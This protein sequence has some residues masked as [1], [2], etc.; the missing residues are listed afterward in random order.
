MAKPHT[1]TAVKSLNFEHRCSHCQYS[2]K[3]KDFH[4][5]ILNCRKFFPSNKQAE[6]IQAIAD[7]YNL[8]Y[9]TLIRH[10]TNH[11]AIDPE[12]ILATEMQRLTNRADA[13]DKLEAMPTYTAGPVPADV[14]NDVIEKARVGLDDGT[15]K[16]TANHLLKAA[17]DK[18][19]FEIKKKNQ[20]MAIQEM[21]WH[22]ASGEAKNSTSYD[23]RIIESGTGTDY[24]PA[25]IFAGIAPE[26]EERSS[27]IH[28]G[29]A[30]DA[31][32]PRTDTVLEGDDF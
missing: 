10:I 1:R 3:H 17:K 21:M 23:R 11:V 2:L 24:D 7:A 22:F 4:N 5:R 8:N 6:T 26:G 18:S 28:P 31:T 20:D 29:V 16:L 14:W 19:D 13:Q 9:I 25:T 27:S 32:A 15:I 12:E 30:G